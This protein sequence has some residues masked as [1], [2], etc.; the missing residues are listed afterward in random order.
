LD[1]FGR[2]VERRSTNSTCELVLKR[3]LPRDAEVSEFCCEV[4]FHDE[5]V[6]G[7][8]VAMENVAL[9]AV[10]KSHRE[11]ADP[12]ETAPGLQFLAGRSVMLD[13]AFEIAPVAEFHDYIAMPPITL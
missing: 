3:E 7:L 2:K 4:V 11:L 10:L 6:L 12:N 13:P 1:D 8:Q 5:N 9:V